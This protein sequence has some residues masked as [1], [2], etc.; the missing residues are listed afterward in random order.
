MPNQPHWQAMDHGDEDMSPEE[1]ETKMTAEEIKMLKDE[2]DKL[3]ADLEE[4]TS[5][6]LARVAKQ[7]QA[8]D[9]SI[10]DDYIDICTAIE[11]WIKKITFNSKKDSFKTKY[12]ENLRHLDAG[13]QIARE[14][15][16][17]GLNPHELGNFDNCDYFILSL[18]IGHSLHEYIFGRPYPIGI[19]IE[20]ERVMDKVKRGMKSP[21]LNKGI[22]KAVLPYRLLANIGFVE[23]S[24][25]DQ[26]RLD[27]VSALIAHQD[28]K[29]E[30]VKDTEEVLAMTKEAILPWLPDS[31]AFV[32]NESKFRRDILDPA[33]RVHR[34]M[35]TSTYSYKM[36][37][38][39]LRA[40]TV[41]QQM[42]DE[43]Y[44]LKDFGTWA[45][46]TN[47][48]VKGILS[49]LYPSIVRFSAGTN[50]EVELLKPVVL[51]TV[52]TDPSLYQ[53]LS[54]SATWSSKEPHDE[55]DSSYLNHP[56][57]SK[58]SKKGSSRHGTGSPE[59]RTP[60]LQRPKSESSGGFF[61]RFSPFSLSSSGASQTKPS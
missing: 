46:V 8:S 26:W 55:S 58:R 30:Q 50:T 5:I 51:V 43:L 4:C 18:I 32:K 25:I 24:S 41:P 6:I 21:A 22:L 35:Q 20:Q 28:F 40:G 60:H 53:P 36:V 37:Y 47:N 42:V 12:M 33:V 19:T 31:G 23:Q 57:H 17:T 15:G 38:P 10:R 61:S 29:E 48:E 11:A 16:Y 3:R 34:A 49:N 1:I 54:R 44:T 14:I 59:R 56:S 52:D 7:D 9:A 39:E 27:T 2:N 45:E 13:R